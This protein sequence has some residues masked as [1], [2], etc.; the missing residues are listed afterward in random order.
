MNTLTSCVPDRL[1]AQRPCQVP[2]RCRGRI[3][4]T[5]T[6]APLG[7]LTSSLSPIA[8]E[9]CETRPYG[10]RRLA[11]PANPPNVR[12]R[13][14]ASETVRS[15]MRALALIDLSRC[16][17]GAKFSITTQHGEVFHSR[18]SVWCGVGSEWSDERV[19]RNQA[20]VPQQAGYG[21]PR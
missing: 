3:R 12:I 16:Q 8:A 1:A 20:A 6:S 15:G 17:K 13:T 4:A 9:I 19:C 11:Q 14:N 18:V 7:G 10:K 21:A 2:S 5:C